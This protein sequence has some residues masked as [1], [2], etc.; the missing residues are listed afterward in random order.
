MSLPRLDRP[1]RQSESGVKF[2]DIIEGDSSL[3][4]SKSSVDVGL[5]LSRTSDYGGGPKGAAPPLGDPSPKSRF[6]EM[7]R[8]VLTDDDDPFYKGRTQQRRVRTF[9]E[10]GN[11]ACA[12]VVLPPVRVSMSGITDVSACTL[13]C[14]LSSPHH[15]PTYAS[16]HLPSH[17]LTMQP[18]PLCHA[19]SHVPAHRLILSMQP[20]PLCHASSHLAM[21]ILFVFPLPSWFGAYAVCTLVF[22]PCT[23]HACAVYALASDPYSPFRCRCMGKQ[24]S[25]K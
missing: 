1:A 21:H 8:S 13:S 11:R 19:P 12:G 14:N 9:S 20:P 2:R 24:K 25:S 16:S 15:A 4:A 18:P 5:R 7:G 10:C 22:S 23:L 17:R 3:Q 6:S